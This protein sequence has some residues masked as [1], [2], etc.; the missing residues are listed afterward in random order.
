MAL[1]LRQQAIIWAIV[2]QYFCRQMVSLRGD[3]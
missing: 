3:E 2:E 1:G